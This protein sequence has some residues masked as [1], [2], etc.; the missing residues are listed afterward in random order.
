MVQGWCRDGAVTA[1]F[2]AYSLNKVFGVL[3]LQLPK[4][5]FG[6]FLAVLLAFTAI[7]AL[8]MGMVQ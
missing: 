3:P 6:A 1:A 7:A 4:G 2:C 8:R 5:F